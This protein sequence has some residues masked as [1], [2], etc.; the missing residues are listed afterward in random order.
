MS[1]PSGK[2][3]APGFILR[4]LTP[5]QLAMVDQAARAAGKSRTEWARERLIEAA[6]EASARSLCLSEEE[7]DAVNEMVWSGWKEA[8]AIREVIGNR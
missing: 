8:D 6:Q 2:H 5:E 7:T 1:G 3:K 4:G